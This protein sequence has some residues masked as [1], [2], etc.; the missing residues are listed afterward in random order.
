MA[1]IPKVG[2]KMERNEY[3]VKGRRNA[4]GDIAHQ[5]TEVNAIELWSRGFYCP[6]NVCRLLRNLSHFVVFFSHQ[7]TT[8]KVCLNITVILPQSVWISIGITLQII[9]FNRFNEN[10]TDWWCWRNVE[11]LIEQISMRNYIGITRAVNSL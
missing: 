7:F 2:P 3:M 6:I 5:K 4:V 11:L 10:E 9:T 1:P 8:V